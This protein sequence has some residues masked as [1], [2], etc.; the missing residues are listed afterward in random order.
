MPK[1][2]QDLGYWMNHDLKNARKIHILL[3]HICKNPF[4]GLGQPKPLKANF[5]G[6]W[7]RRINHEH[8]IIYKVE[9]EK[10]I[11]HSLFGHYLD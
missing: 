7:F 6:Y 3:K 8:F 10:I 11:V 5:S 9:Q 2:W 4:E 1:A